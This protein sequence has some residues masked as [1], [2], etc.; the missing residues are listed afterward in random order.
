MYGTMARRREEE[1]MVV[2]GGGRYNASLGHQLGQ[3][4]WGGAGLTA[5]R[6]AGTEGRSTAAR[7]GQRQLR[8]ALLP[9]TK[10]FGWRPVLLQ[11]PQR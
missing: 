3:L 11:V 10:T 1:Q 7:S 8:P 4:D 6:C 2:G 9:S 5:G